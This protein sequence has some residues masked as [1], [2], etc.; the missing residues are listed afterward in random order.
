MGVDAISIDGFECAGH[1]GEDDIPG[2]ILIPAAADK[3]KIPMIASAASATRAAWSPRWRWARKASTWAPASAPPSRA[4]IHQQHQGADRRQRRARHRPD[5]PHLHNT[6]RV[7]KQ[8]HQPEVVT[9]EARR[10]QIRRRQAPGGRRARRGA[11]CYERR[12]DHGIWSA[13]MVQGLIHDIPTCRNWCRASSPT[14]KRSSPGA[15][16][17]S[18]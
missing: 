3:V 2:L 5:L 13:G 10:R 11:A 7:A 9:I 16:P 6:A 4:P 1:P 8:R 14:P 17:A 18:S 15:W 12:P